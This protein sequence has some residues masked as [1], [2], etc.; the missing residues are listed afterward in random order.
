MDMDTEETNSL[1]SW[2]QKYEALKEEF[3]DFRETSA[4]FEAEL[5]LEIKDQCNQILELTKRY[6]QHKLETDLYKERIE[7]QASEQERNLVRLNN[8]NE[9]YS[10]RN[11]FLTS[12]VRQLEQNVDD[13]DRAKRNF[14]E[15]IATLEYQ[16]ANEYERNAL[17]EA[18]VDQRKELEIECQRLRD[19]ARDL[20]QDRLRE[21]K[22]ASVLGNGSLGYSSS[23][24]SKSVSPCSSLQNC[25]N[26]NMQLTAIPA[27]H[28]N[29][30]TVQ[31]KQR[32]DY[33]RYISSI[34]PVRPKSY[35]QSE[36]FHSITKQQSSSSAK[37]VR[38][39][40]ISSSDN[41]VK[42]PT[43]REFTEFE[44]RGRNI[45]SKDIG[46][47]WWASRWKRLQTSFKRG[48]SNSRERTNFNNENKDST[49]TPKSRKNKRY[50]IEQINNQ[51]SSKSKNR[52]IQQRKFDNNKESSSPQ[53]IR[54]ESSGGFTQ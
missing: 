49:T 25:Q 53:T 7:K 6:D 54:S 29:D 45:N 33:D 16:L 26:S 23:S 17:L 19:Q 52:S 41:T 44:A 11:N 27:S 2:K 15:T 28:M 21:K 8:Q 40:S 18:D 10:G 24:N 48:K 47:N 34:S 14:L 20:D 39:D 50:G 30:S 36:S 32:K 4:E 3:D 13:L 42:S 37:R 12:A 22:R 1:E 9:E 35:K 38:P 46:E 31:P 51:K 5:D 43:K